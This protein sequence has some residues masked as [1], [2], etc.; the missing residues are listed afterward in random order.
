MPKKR[1]SVVLSIRLDDQSL[2]AVDLLV[3][4]G[5]ETN[6]SRA[7]AHFVT[8]GIQA[9]EALLQK[10][11]VLADH[12]HRLR[13]E[14]IDAVKH[15]NVEKVTE[16][17]RQDSSL[18]NV[19]NS[20]GETALLIATYLRANEIKELLIDHG[21]ELS[22]FE[23]SAIGSTARVKQLLEMAPELIGAYGPDGFQPLSM[24][25]HFGN[26]E[27]VKLLLDCGADVNARSRDGSLNNMAIHAAI[28]GNYEHIIRILIQYGA[29][30]NAQCEGTQRM[31]YTALHVAAYFGR[32]SLIE[33]FLHHGA[34][35]AI[36]NADGE[37]PY[38]LAVSKG[39]QQAAERLK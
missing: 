6:R 30:V 29:D 15:N 13:N 36:R 11:Q 5:L 14:M 7:A 19:S 32:D 26:E 16:L 24:A 2:K 23:A 33:L 38:D 21:A 4:S 22:I 17:I 3:E 34:D 31:G 37:T 20:K 12:V 1:N 27:T 39:H 35:P 28:L 25:A 10:A 9:S 18:V 8:A